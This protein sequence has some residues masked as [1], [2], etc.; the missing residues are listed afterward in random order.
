[1][2]LLRAID[3]SAYPLHVRALERHATWARDFAAVGELDAAVDALD[4]IRA[5]TSELDVAL[6]PS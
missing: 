3:R 1:M 2:S 4:D 5:L 6:S